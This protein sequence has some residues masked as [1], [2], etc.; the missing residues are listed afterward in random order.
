MR[1]LSGRE[2][3]GKASLQVTVVKDAVVPQISKRHC[4]SGATEGLFPAQTTG[5]HSPPH[6]AP[7][8]GP[9]TEPSQRHPASLLERASLIGPARSLPASLRLLAT[10]P[11]AALFSCLRACLLGKRTSQVRLGSLYRTDRALCVQT[12]WF[13]FQIPQARTK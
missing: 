4:C 10:P 9:F 11:K 7:D 8:T 12:F 3:G 13:C 1:I 6:P 2:R 5:S